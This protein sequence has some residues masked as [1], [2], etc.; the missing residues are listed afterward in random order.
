VQ[1]FRAFLWGVGSN[2]QVVKINDTHFENNIRPKRLNHSPLEKRASGCNT[3]HAL[4]PLHSKSSSNSPSNPSGAR[5]DFEIVI[6]LS[7][8][9]ADSP[10]AES[11]PVLNFRNTGKGECLNLET[12]VD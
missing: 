7:K 5:L 1:E 6:A 3:L 2:D 9:E 11:D 4:T 10:R 12:F 8:V